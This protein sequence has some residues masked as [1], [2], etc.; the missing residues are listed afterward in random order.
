LKKRD[1]LISKVKIFRHL[2][3]DK[4]R[5]IAN[6]SEPAYFNDGDHCIEQGEKGHEFYIIAKGMKKNVFF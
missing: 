5:Q 2:Q 1:E 3:E 4:V 6:R